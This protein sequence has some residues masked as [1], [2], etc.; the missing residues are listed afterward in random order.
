MKYFNTFNITSVFVMML[1]VVAAGCDSLTGDPD[2]P[3]PLDETINEDNTGAFLRVVSVESPAINYFDISN[4]EY[5]FVGEV[6]DSDNGQKTETVNFYVRYVDEDGNA[7]AET[8]N[9]FA[10]YSVGDLSVNEE[11]GLPRTTFT[12]TA[13]EMISAVDGIDGESLTEGDLYVGGRFDIRMELVMKDGRTFSD[14]DV[15]PAV[16]GGFYSS[17]M[18]ARAAVTVIIDESK[19]VGEYQITQQNTST[20]G[21]PVFEDMQFTTELRVNPNNSANGRVFDTAIYGNLN[22][23][24]G[25]SGYT[26]PLVL[27]RSPE[28]QPQNHLTVDGTYG[29]GLSCGGPELVFAPEDDPTLSSFDVDD[30]SQFSFA[31]IDNPNG[32]CGAPEVLVRFNAVKQ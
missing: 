29:T 18:Q 7:T 28:S 32:A 20:F 11:S 16:T 22:G 12:F 13:P 31:L 15:S 8:P 19:Y 3:I 21:G 26:I 23:G 2:L 10:S 25:F 27:A 9:P 4:S 24:N 14:E 5:S 1:L 17:P 30:D 6:S